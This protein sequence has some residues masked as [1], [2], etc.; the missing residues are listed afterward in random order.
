MSALAPLAA[1]A[2]AACGA[3][4]PTPPYAPQL[5]SALAQVPYPP[6]PARVET[7]PP[8]P[9]ADAVWID[10][11]WE[12]RRR[13]VWRVGGWVVAPR[14]AAYAPWVAVRGADGTLFFAPAT[15]RDAHGNEIDPPPVL[16]AAIPAPGAVVGADGE[17]EPTGIDRR[18][19]TRRKNTGE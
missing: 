12:W 7:V 9:R 6:P 19:S 15:W 8:Q 10:G 1:C 16:A 5:T 3:R 2:L 18:G 13:W 14:G 11:S 17:V 4:L